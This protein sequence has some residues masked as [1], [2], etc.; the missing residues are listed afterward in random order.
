M[1]S[2]QYV[3]G[4]H[5]AGQALGGKAIMQTASY[6]YQDTNSPPLPTRFS[7]CAGQLDARVSHLAGMIDRLSRIADRLGG[8]VPEEIQKPGQI[9]GASANTA[10]QLEQALE[11]FDE[12]TR[13][14]ERVV[15]RLESL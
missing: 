9:R 4:I 7:N 2:N 8:P 12:I 11:L 3:P 5:S 15:E 10:A 14:A 1:N 6:G 13:R